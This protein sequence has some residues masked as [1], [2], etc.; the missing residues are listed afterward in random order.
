MGIGIGMLLGGLGLFLLGMLLMTDGLK[1][2]AGPLLGRVLGWSTET[3]W[4]GLLAGMLLTGLV[5]SSS[6][7]TVATIGFV[8]AGLLDLG[9]SLWVLFGANVG[10]TATG[11]LVAL[12]GF[13]IKIELAALPL[14][15]VGMGLRL[16]G[17]Q[18]RRGA[19]G[20]ALAGFGVLFLGIGFMQQAIVIDGPGLPWGALGGGPLALLAFV[21]VGLALTVLMQSSSA[22]LAIT[23]TLAQGGVVSLTAAAAMVIG[24]NIGTTVTALLAAVGA[25]PNAR[26]AASAHVAFN[27][28]AATVALLLLPLLIHGVEGVRSL[29]GFKASPAVSLAIFHSVFNV[30]GVALMWPLA[31]R[32]TIFLKR[33]FRTRDEDAGQPRYL[34]SNVASVPSLAADAMRRELQRLGDIALTAAWARLGHWHGDDHR[35]QEAAAYISLSQRIHDFVTGVNRG[36]MSERSAQA[37]AT[38]LRVQRYYD[39]CHELSGELVIAPPQLHEPLQTATRA[40]LQQGEQLLRCLDPARNEFAP[41]DRVQA[42]AFEADY[43]ALKAGLLAAGAAGQLEIG[44]MDALLRSFSS[45]RRIIAQADKAAHLLASLEEHGDEE[46]EKSEKGDGEN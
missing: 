38:L 24:S 40:L 12:V 9:Q 7:V 39:T 20:S 13:K 35:P 15:G 42:E 19:L 18:S 29:L 23:L 32:L 44:R 26:R 37:M 33:R 31:R 45:L 21:L 36:S 1:Q 27:L 30:L 14:I 41:L 17:P 28:V 2:A 43:Q 5:Q 8:N 46:E 34:D 22:V 4:R 11:W 10:T 6:A 3:R 16:S 25:T